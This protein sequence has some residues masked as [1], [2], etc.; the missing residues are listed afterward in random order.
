MVDFFSKQPFAFSLVRKFST[1]FLIFTDFNLTIP[2]VINLCHWY[3]PRLVLLES[4][5]YPRNTK[6]EYSESQARIKMQRKQEFT[7]SG[8]K[9]Q[10][11]PQISHKNVHGY[12]NFTPVN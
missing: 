3:H 5:V 7:N 4:R 12:F 1:L 8:A 2:L 10:P 11:I 9:L 6:P